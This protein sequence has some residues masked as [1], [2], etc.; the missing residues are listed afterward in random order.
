MGTAAQPTWAN[1]TITVVFGHGAQTRRN[2]DTGEFLMRNAP[3]GTKP[4]PQ[5]RPEP[6]HG[7]DMDCTQAVA[8]VILGVFAPSMVDLLMVVSPSTPACIHTVCICIHTCPW[9]NRRFD[10]RCNGLVL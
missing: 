8:I 10:K 3:M 5:Q 9:S 2:R 7:M 1:R 6:F 4:A